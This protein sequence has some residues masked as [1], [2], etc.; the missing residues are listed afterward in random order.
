MSGLGWFYALGLLVTL[1]L[2]VR[3]IRR[4][5]GLFVLYLVAL[6]GAMIGGKVGYLAAEGWMDFRSQDAWIRLLS[7]KTIVG[8]LLGGYVFVEIGKLLL[9]EGRVTGD[10]FAVLVPLGIAIGRVGCVFNGCC[11]GRNGWPAAEV[12]LG[13][14]LVAALLAV[15][16]RRAGLFSGQLFHGYLIAYG[17]FRFG[18]EFV[19]ETPA[20]CLGVTGY[21][22][23]ALILVALGL[24][25][26]K[27]RSLEP[28]PASSSS[29]DCK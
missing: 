8:A 22:I 1:P 19:R 12:E 5:R 26:W 24:L 16:L 6:F 7:G 27:R 23:L 3:L 20:C 13:F 9:G 17:L 11:P 25:G 4:D 29:L 15:S 18:H 10:F 14:N 2:W 21:Q 28:A